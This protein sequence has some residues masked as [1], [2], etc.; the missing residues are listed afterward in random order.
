MF[1]K[2]PTKENDGLYYVRA[3]QDD[4][5]KVFYQLNAAK[6]KTAT[7][8]E[9]VLEIKSRAKIDTLDE[10]NIQAAI[11][12]AQEWFGKELTED[13][14]RNAYTSP[15]DLTVE[16]IHPTKVFS[17][18]LEIVDFESA[19]AGRECN[20]IV[21]FAGL[22]FARQSFGPVFNVVQVKLHATKVS[23]YPED[24]AFVEDEDD[25]PEPAPSAQ[26]PVEDEPEPETVPVEESAPTEITSE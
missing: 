18:E 21:E 5:K 14:L 22:Y 17:P 2:P 13:Y 12:H 4:G 10:Q 25:E 15:R 19:A 3:F 9:L 7:G 24:Y 20:A 8:S 6:I 16:R 11:E 1:F 26:P 23:D